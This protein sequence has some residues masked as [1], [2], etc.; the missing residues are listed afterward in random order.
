MTERRRRLFWRLFPWVLVFGLGVTTG[1]YARD[2]QQHE[3]LRDAVETARK[4][5]EKAGLEA[6]ERARGAG[7]GFGAGAEAA[8]ESTKA[9]FRR[10]LRGSDNQ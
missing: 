4:D 1:F 3:R 5:M 7:A 8:A 10:L 2:R 9:A 6:I